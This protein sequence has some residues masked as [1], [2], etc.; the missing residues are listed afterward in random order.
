MDG[1]PEDAA[2]ARR[3]ALKSPGGG[4]DYPVF[5]E[6]MLVGEGERVAAGRPFAIVVSARDRRR[7]LAAPMDGHIVEIRHSYG[8][9]LPRQD[10]LAILETFAPVPKP[11]RPKAEDP[12][13]GPTREAPRPRNAPPPEAGRSATPGGPA[14]D[15]VRDEDRVAEG[16]RRA[17]RHGTA[18]KAH[19]PSARPPRLPRAA[20]DIL[21]VATPGFANG[22]GTL[23]DPMPRGGLLGFS[24]TALVL[25]P[26]VFLLAAHAGYA[27]PTYQHLI[28]LLPIALTI[29]ALMT[30]TVLF[31]TRTRLGRR[32]GETTLGLSMGA[33][34]VVVM[35]GLF[36]LAQT[37]GILEIRSEIELPELT[38]FLRTHFGHL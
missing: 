2:V 36:Y 12:P 35:H 3:I 28:L 27:L 33:V 30:L 1:M 24:V 29:G 18:L 32:I 20:R 16:E 13:T 17:D 10:V 4:F 14:G 9:S 7:V 15:P 25:L 26:I 34:L 23:A 8:A 5:V 22:G 37:P 19:R 11:P 21:R 31:H 6:R 38:N